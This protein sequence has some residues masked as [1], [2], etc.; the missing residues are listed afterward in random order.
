[1]RVEGQY[2]REVR[3]YGEC[4]APG[5][6]QLDRRMLEVVAV[7]AD[8]LPLLDVQ[9]TL[10]VTPAASRRARQRRRPRRCLPPD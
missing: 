3:R 4:W 5:Q 9:R 2:G 6:R 8:W 1:M 7:S 10:R